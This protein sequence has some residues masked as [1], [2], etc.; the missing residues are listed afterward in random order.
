M[1]ALPPSFAERWT[2][3]IPAVSAVNTDA[4]EPFLCLLRAPHILLG[5]QKDAAI[6]TSCSWGTPLP[7]LEDRDGE[8]N[9][10]P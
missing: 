1:S 4:F 5:T 6:H 10:A 7:E 8:Q 3:L 2:S 9:G